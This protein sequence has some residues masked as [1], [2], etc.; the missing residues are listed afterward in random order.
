MALEALA[1]LRLEAETRLAG[2]GACERVDLQ[3]GSMCGVES[4]R[5][6]WGGVQQES[7]PLELARQELKRS[8]VA[9][10][11]SSVVVK[12]VTAN[13][14]TLHPSEERKVGHNFTARSRELQYLANQASVDILGVQEARTVSARRDGDQYVIL[15]SGSDGRGN[16]GCEAWFA[17]RLLRDG[18]TLT[19]WVSQ[20]RIL[21]VALRS[22]QLN[23]DIDPGRPF[24]STSKTSDAFVLL[25]DAALCKVRHHTVRTSCGELWGR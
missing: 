14:L 15:S 17:F 25:H 10:A 13:V 11:G 6:F 12:V 24:A 7:D 16:Y 5:L 19:P 3:S 18:G 22:R 23:V 9:V 20:P 4:A 21:G 8:P 2:T 1:C